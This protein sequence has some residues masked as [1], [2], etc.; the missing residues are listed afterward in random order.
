[1]NKTLGL[2]QLEAP[3]K[4][5]RELVDFLREE[6]RNQAAPLATV[7]LLVSPRRTEHGTSRPTMA[8]VAGAIQQWYGRCNTNPG[9][10]AI[11]YFCGHGIEKD[12]QYLLME[13]FGAIESSLLS[14]TLNLNDFRHGM[15]RCAAQTQLLLID[16]CRDAPRDLKIT[17]SGYPVLDI[18]PTA[19]WPRAG[20][21]L[22]T[23]KGKK[24]FARRKGESTQFVQA[25]L[26]ALRGAA[27]VLDPDNTDRWSVHYNS[28]GSTMNQLLARIENP[29]HRQRVRQVGESDDALIHELDGPPTVPVI[30]ECD[31]ATC[32]RLARLTMRSLMNGRPPYLRDPPADGPWQVMAIADAY[33]LSAQLR[34]PWMSP[35]ER[36]VWVLPP[37]REYRVKARR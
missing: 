37:Y 22:A 33:S 19:A 4:S 7:D 25:L 30:V 15:A 14:N 23:E 31:P 16:A 3:W 1:L 6:Y 17:G 29:A 34:P 10:V 13:D 9:N 26:E 28:L 27:A 20:T 12:A 32:A 8:A 36:N 35:P 24:A 11:F 18:D 2:K 21:L 5:T